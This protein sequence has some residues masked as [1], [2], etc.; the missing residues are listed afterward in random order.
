MEDCHDTV[1]RLVLYCSWVVT[2]Y[3]YILS[4]FVVYRPPHVIGP[5]VCEVSA[6]RRVI[7]QALLYGSGAFFWCPCPLVARVPV[8]VLLKFVLYGTLVVPGVSGCDLSAA[9]IGAVVAEVFIPAFGQRL[10]E[11][12][13]Y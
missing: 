11:E 3:L 9:C 7:G 1:S 5:F 8:S 4:N 6:W 12:S 10:A 13:T 2:G